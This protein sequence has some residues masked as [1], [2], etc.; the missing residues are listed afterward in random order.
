[1][2]E[3]RAA[4]RVP[5]PETTEPQW[6]AVSEAAL[7]R[8]AMALLERC[9][10][11]AY[12][13]HVARRSQ[14]GFPDIVAVDAVWPRLTRPLLIFA[15]L[16]TERGR[17]IGRRTTPL[18]R[19]LPDQADWLAALAAAA[20]MVNRLFLLSGGSPLIWTGV[21]RP[22]GADEFR[23]LLGDDGQVVDLFGA[24]DRLVLEGEKNGPAI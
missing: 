9:G 5:L 23:R 1:M 2:T 11:M 20:R 10:Y 6:L 12:H 7:Q 13:V 4:Y 16:K 24:L 22:S 19:M 3:R 17:L 8:W 14:T 18:G 15:E 21:L